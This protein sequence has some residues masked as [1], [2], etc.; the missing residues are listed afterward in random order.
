MAFADATQSFVSEDLPLLFP[1]F[2][3]G[4]PAPS[5]RQHTHVLPRRVV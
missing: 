5:S 2:T 3:A 4:N 1:L